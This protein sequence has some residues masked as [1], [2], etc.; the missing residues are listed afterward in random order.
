MFSRFDTDGDKKVTLKEFKMGVK[1]DKDILD[2]LLGFGVAKIEDVGM[3]FGAGLG[4]A[5]DVNPDLEN[6]VKPKSLERTDKKQHMKDGIEYNVQ[7]NDEEGGMFEVG[8]E[9]EGD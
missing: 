4:G 8:E 2:I 1:Q 7:E 3:D 5:P 6:E 9:I